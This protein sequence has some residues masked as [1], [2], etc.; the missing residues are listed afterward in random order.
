MSS[1]DDSG[2][3]AYARMMVPSTAH[4]RKHSQHASMAISDADPNIAFMIL[5]GGLEDLKGCV[6]IIGVE[7]AELHRQLLRI[8]STMFSSRFRDLLLRSQH[9][10]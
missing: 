7:S 5:W 3:W 10:F 1:T 2:E 4:I 8:Y 6:E 9:M